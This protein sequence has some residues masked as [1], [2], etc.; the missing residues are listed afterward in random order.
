[1]L[2]LNDQLAEDACQR[3]RVAMQALREREV[4][5][6]AIKQRA[7]AIA[8]EAHISSKTLYRSE[9][10][11]L[12]HPEHCLNTHES[13]EACKPPEP[14]RVSPSQARAEGEKAR[15]PSGNAS[16]TLER[17]NNPE[18]YTLERAMKCDPLDEPLPQTKYSFRG[19]RGDWLRF[20]QSVEGYIP[21]PIPFEEVHAAIQ[22]K[23]SRLSWSLEQIRQFLAEHFQGRSCIW[24][25]QAHELTT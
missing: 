11:E 8:C 4:L 24:Q 23:A 16:R 21:A 2:N 5:P 6:M 18:V 25:L 1:V 17:R 13:A 22:Q 10:L 19:V 3:I 20:P 14:A 9:N 12:W 7:A 15:F